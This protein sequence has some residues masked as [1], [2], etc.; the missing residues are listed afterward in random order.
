MC[1]GSLVGFDP[2]VYLQSARIALRITVVVALADV[3]PERR[4]LPNSWESNCNFLAPEMKRY[5]STRTHQQ[6][7]AK[8]ATL[9][10]LRK[11]LHTNLPWKETINGVL[12]FPILAGKSGLCKA[13]SQWPQSMLKVDTETEGD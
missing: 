4:T 6:F 9:L 12:S 11:P 5:E 3:N 2:H 7:T 8:A 10:F 13:T 1:S